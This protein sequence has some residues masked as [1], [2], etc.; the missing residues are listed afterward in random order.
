MLYI[1]IR[2]FPHHRGALCLVCLCQMHSCAFLPCCSNKALLRWCNLRLCGAWQNLSLPCACEAE[3]SQSVLHPELYI[4]KN[5]LMISS[6][7]C[8]PVFTRPYLKVFTL[9]IP[10]L[11]IIQSLF[12]TLFFYNQGIFF[13]DSEF[14]PPFKNYMGF[15]MRGI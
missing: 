15:L 14:S 8:A 7:K 1:P 3:V 11:S 12:V 5:L 2:E 10:F 6:W 9:R 13:R 4:F